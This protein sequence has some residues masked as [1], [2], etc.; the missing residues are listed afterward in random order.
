MTEKLKALRQVMAKQKLAAYL[1]PVHDEYMSEYPPA[2]N[3]RLEWFT[4]FSGSAG[5]VAALLKKA[6]FF[7]DGRYTLQ[8]KQQVSQKLFEQH[9]SGEVTPEAW[10]SGQLRAGER[11]GYDP[12]L[13]TPGM[14]RRMR[15]ALEHKGI[16]LAAVS[17][18]VDAIWKN[19]PAAPATPVLIHGLQYAGETSTSKRRRVAKKI[20]TLGAD[21]AVITAPD[22][23]CWLLN[24]RAHDIENAPLLLATAILD[25]RGHAQLYVSPE[26]C[27]AKAKKHLKNTR[28][29]DPVLLAADLKALG[30]KKRRVLCDPQSAPVWFSQTLSKAGAIIVEAEDPCLL[31]KAIKNPVELQGMRSAH[32]RDGVA[33]TKLLCWLDNRRPERPVSEMDVCAKL[34][35]FRA[36]QPDFV[37]PSFPT[38]SGSGPHGAIVHYR[39][40]PESDRVLRRGELM[41]LDSGGQY[42]DGTTD[43]TRTVPI[44]NP[45]PEQISSFT[46]VLKGH[47]ALARAKFPAGTR[48]SQLDALARQFLWQAGLDY[49]HGTGHGV[50]HFLNVHEGPQRISKRG[51]DAP[52]QPGMIVS[53]EPGYYKAGEYGIRIES[54]V[55]VRTVEREERKAGGEASAPSAIRHPPS[56]GWLAFETLTCVPIDTRLVDAAMLA[57]EEKDWLNA[58]HAWVLAMLSDA[59]DAAERGWLKVRCAAV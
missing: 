29:R 25:A 32:I 26:R 20:K 54:L 59:L 23:V 3:R 5:T 16:K 12:K 57:P 9:N 37:E 27:D 53:N 30:E 55:I 8:A 2:C 11:V 14:L 58:Y 19:R 56:T 18:P 46:R 52:F 13:Y 22:A 33:V 51:G 35:A 7:T 17:N 15:Q 38:I 39:A 42:P 48:G 45:S 40:T 43:I 31:A 28:L 47:I 24:I 1:Q 44:G 34:R 50:G 21:A 10:L 49:D 6:A 36:A 4:G 41:L